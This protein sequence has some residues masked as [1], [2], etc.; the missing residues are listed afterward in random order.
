MERG[1]YKGISKLRVPLMVSYLRNPYA[2]R[3]QVKMSQKCRV[4]TCNLTHPSHIA[5]VFDGQPVL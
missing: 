1:N 4:N 3:F 5:V 2:N